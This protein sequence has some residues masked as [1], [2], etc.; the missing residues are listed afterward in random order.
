MRIICVGAGKGGTG[1]TTVATA[2]AAHLTSYYD[3][4]LLDTDLSCPSIFSLFNLEGYQY[5]FAEN[6]LLLPPVC[7]GHSKG[8]ALKIFSLGADIPPDQ[9]VAWSGTQLTD[10]LRDQFISIEWG[11]ID[12]MVIDMPPGTSD[13]VQAILDFVPHSTIV[14]VILNQ[15]LSL[16]DCRKFIE[17]CKHKKH[18]VSPC[19]INLSDVFSMYD[20]KTIYEMMQVKVMMHL[21]FNQDW[22]AEDAGLRILESIDKDKARAFREIL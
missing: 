10:M 4:G 9:H 20:D 21:P 3:V 6:G 7:E 8:S 11:S 22:A 1:K 5:T 16:I 14:P 15:K 19:I 17:L 13:N 18:S 2:I 12:V